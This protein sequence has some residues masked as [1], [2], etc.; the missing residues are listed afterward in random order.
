M[1]IGGGSYPETSGEAEVLRYIQKKIPF[2]STPLLMDVGA[3]KGDYS[4]LILNIFGEKCK[5]MAFEPAKDMY[6]ALSK[7]L[8][9]TQALSFP[10]GLGSSSG[11]FQLY[12]HPDKPGLSSVY[13][14]N[15]THLNM[16]LSQTESITLDTLEAF[17]NARNITFIDFLKIDVEGHELEVLKGAGKLLSNC[18]IRF[19]QFEF[20]GCNLDSR[21]YLRDFFMLLNES[22]RIYRIVTDGLHPLANY[23]EIL[24]CF[25][26]TNF[27]A[28]K[29][30]Q[31]FEN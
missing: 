21:T 22:Y 23:Y 28:E 29:I 12:R 7:R 20:G 11:T 15:L 25:T 10:F 1:T 9:G 8:L 3:N 17:C 27:L 2:N 4:V 14:R 5:L 24:E 19:I 16:N 26:T 13:N 31:S 18:Q 30:N 6:E